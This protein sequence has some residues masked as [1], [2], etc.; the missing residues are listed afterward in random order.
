MTEPYVVCRDVILRPLA[1]GSWVLSNPRVR[2]HVQVD[3]AGAAAVIA[4]A[5]TGADEDEW[6]ARL[7]SITVHQRSALS[8]AN[9][10]LSDP[11]GIA[12]SAGAARSGAAAFEELRQAW[13]VCKT[14]H[15]DYN[16]FL[17]PLVSLLDRS[18]LGSF[19]QQIG[20][21]L[22]LELRQKQTWRWW[23]DQKFEPDGRALRPGPY[24]FVQRHFFDEFFDKRDLRGMRILDFACGNGFY[25]RRFSDRGADVIGLDTSAELIEI[26]NRNHGR[27]ATFVRPDTDND[28]AVWLD[29]AAPD[30][31]DVIYVSDALLFFFTSP[32]TGKRNDRPAIALLTRLQRLLRRTGTLYVMEPNGIFWLSAPVGDPQR[33]YALITEYRDQLYHVAPTTDRVITTLAAAGFHVIGLTHPY[34]D[35]DAPEGTTNSTMYRYAQQF[36]LWDFYEC[37]PRPGN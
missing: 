5:P 17:G 25:S 29:A 13:I 18:H 24:D 27:A 22:L 2:R 9:G 4:V 26:A 28:V 36:P 6:K 10:L 1:D 15:Q 16:Q 7:A 37:C 19:H 34:P 3:A 11:S 20:R 12:S 21:Y 32:E 30:S 35:A 14:G 8:I 33:P 31:F 23:H